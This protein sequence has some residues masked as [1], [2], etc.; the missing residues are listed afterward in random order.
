MSRFPTSYAR[1]ARPGLRIPPQLFVGLA[2]ALISVVG[3]CAKQTI[4]PVTGRK[5]AVSLSVP[6][7]VAMG[8]QAAPELIRQMGGLS[9]D[10]QAA[11]FVKSVG[12]R[13]VSALPPGTGDYRYDFHLIADPKTV[14]AFALPG[15]QVFIT[16]ALFAR[17]ETEG[18]LAGVL[19]HEIGHVVGRH[20]SER[21]AKAEL[22]Q[23]IVGGVTI[24]ASGESM[25][26]VGGRG[27]GMLAQTIGNYLG[28]SYSREHE[29]ESDQLGLRFMYA[30]G[31]DPRSLIRVMQIL[32]E[33]SGGRSNAPDFA[34]THPNPGRRIERI[35]L[36]LDEMFPTGVPGGLKP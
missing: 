24:G 34:A 4:N 10:Q 5:Q 32:E 17:L 21:M 18:Q 2:I 28:L 13:L 20:S 27:A 35:E 14:N 11:R 22:T 7:E 33:A 29:L 30:A 9:S 19:G 15:G 16:E 36:H 12:N 6:Q 1:P 31:Y 23:G 8:L 25:G 3:Y 26:G